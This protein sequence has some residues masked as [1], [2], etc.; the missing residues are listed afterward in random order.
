MFWDNRK[1]PKLYLSFCFPIPHVIY[2]EMIAVHHYNPCWVSLH[3]WLIITFKQGGRIHEKAVFKCKNPSYISP[4][5]LKTLWP[6]F[7][8]ISKPLPLILLKSLGYLIRSCCPISP[9]P[10]PSSSCYSA[11]SFSTIKGIQISLSSLLST[12]LHGIIILLLWTASSC[13]SFS[14]LSLPMNSDPYYIQTT[15]ALFCPFK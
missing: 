13:P 4:L 3:T 14:S 11:N 9:P 7:F 8:C 12:L 2:P 6:Q 5:Y 15:D 1:T 10:T